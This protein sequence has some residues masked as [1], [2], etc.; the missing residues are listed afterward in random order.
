MTWCFPKQDELNT[1]ICLFKMHIFSYPDVHPVVSMV[2]S[3]ICVSSGLF[4]LSGI[5]RPKYKMYGALLL[6]GILAFFAFYPYLDTRSA[7]GTVSRLNFAVLEAIFV[8]VFYLI[9]HI[10]SFCRLP[11]F[12]DI[13]V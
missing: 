6:S 7:I 3:G 10:Y 8:N 4:M 13:L 11:F 2:V 5:P 12:L 1:F 9:I